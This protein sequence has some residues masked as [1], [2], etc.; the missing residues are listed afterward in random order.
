M[1]IAQI[2]SATAS[3]RLWGLMLRIRNTLPLFKTWAVKCPRKRRA[4]AL[5]TDRGLYEG[6]EMF[7]ARRGH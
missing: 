7:P 3:A 1:I 2:K 6:D 5:E 4:K